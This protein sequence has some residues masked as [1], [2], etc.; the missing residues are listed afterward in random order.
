MTDTPRAT[1]R[2]RYGDSLEGQHKYATHL[3]ALA[4]IL[5]G[6]ADRARRRGISVLEA[7]LH[8]AAATARACGEELRPDPDARL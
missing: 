8:E 2:P 3:E 6:E 7:R 5:D 4:V 1:A